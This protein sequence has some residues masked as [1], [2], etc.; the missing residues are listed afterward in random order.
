MYR[1]NIFI[2]PILSSVGNLIFVRIQPAF[3]TGYSKSPKL[4][5][6]NRNFELELTDARMYVYIHIYIYVGPMIDIYIYIYLCIYTIYTCVCKENINQKEYYC[7]Y[8]EYSNQNMGK[9]YGR[10]MKK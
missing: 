6:N 2:Y 4:L 10:E 8:G 1:V 7:K 3:W 9:I 5:F